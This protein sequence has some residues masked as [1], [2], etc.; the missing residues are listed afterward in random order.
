MAAIVHR[1]RELTQSVG[2]LY[3]PRRLASRLYR[4]QEQRNEHPDDGDHHQELDEC[5][6]FLFS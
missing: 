5:K 4:G 3:A 1:K 2:T 6:S